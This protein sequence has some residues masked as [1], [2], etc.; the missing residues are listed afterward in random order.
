M[1][2]WVGGWVGLPISVLNSEDLEVGGF[3]PL[4]DDGFRGLVPG[5][6]ELPIDHHFG[7][8]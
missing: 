5:G 8:D 4:E 1:G 7:D 2:G 6:V 3:H